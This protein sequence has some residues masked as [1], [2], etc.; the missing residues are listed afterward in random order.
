MSAK[1]FPSLVTAKNAAQNAHQHRLDSLQSRRDFV[2]LTTINKLLVAGF[3]HPAV[4]CGWIC[5]NAGTQT[6]FT[7]PVFYRFLMA[8]M[9]QQ[10]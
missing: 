8:C 3:I 7:R 5:S 10:V 2:V 4:L 6:K 1:T 9:L